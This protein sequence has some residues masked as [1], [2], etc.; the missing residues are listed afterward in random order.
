MGSTQHGFIGIRLTCEST[1]GALVIPV[2]QG[3]MAIPYLTTTL[4]IAFLVMLI[5]RSSIQAVPGERSIGRCKLR[6]SELQLSLHQNMIGVIVL[7]V[8]LFFWNKFPIYA[9][10]ANSALIISSILKRN[11]T[12]NIISDLEY[13]TYIT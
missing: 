13:T 10:N 2:Q 5:R 8:S 4:H 11:C 7:D 12:C 6:L 1:L 9:G 3:Q